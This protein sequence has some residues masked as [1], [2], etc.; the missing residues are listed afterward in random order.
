MTFRPH[1]F[2]AARDT[3]R[4]DT[5]R[6]SPHGRLFLRVV[7]LNGLRLAFGPLRLLSLAVGIRL[8]LAFVLRRLAFGVIRFLYLALGIPLLRR[9]AFGPLRLSF[10]VLRLASCLCRSSL[11]LGLRC[12]LLLFTN[13]FLLRECLNFLLL[14]ELLRCGFSLS[15]PL[16]RLRH[17]FLR[18][19]VVAA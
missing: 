9:R 6:P 15:D 17:L 3:P 1:S 18:R 7:G 11:C 14:H 4:P 8:R 2:F 5:A 12:C 10:G 19:R 16:A 13:R